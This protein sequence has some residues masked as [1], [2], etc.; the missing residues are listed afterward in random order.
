MVAWHVAAGDAV[1][2]N[3]VLAEVETEKAVVELPSPFAGTVVELLAPTGRHG[4]R[5]LAARRRS[6][7]RGRGEP[8]RPPRR[9]RRRCRSSWATARPR[10]RRAGA[11]AAGGGPPAT[12]AAPHRA[13]PAAAT[14]SAL[15]APR[16][17]SRP[18]QAGVDLADVAGHGPGGIVTREDLAA[19]VAVGPP[20]GRR[21]RRRRETRAPG[22]RRAEAHGRGHGAQRHR[23]P[24]ACVFLTVDVTPSVELVQRLRANRHFEGLHVTAAGPGR[25]GRGPRPRAPAVANSSWDEAARRGRDQALREPGH[26]GG[27][28]RTAWSC[29]TSRT[30]RTSRCATWCG[31]STR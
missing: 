6:T 22:P 31:P 9:S 7:P 13:A 10:L 3:Q 26:R 16:C 29:P 20:A 25:P 15:A 12:T 28:A 1:T 14:S 11:V 8:R 4:G 17:A 21:Q 2:L 24:Q 27:R 18:R 23:G 19:H 5:R 30:R